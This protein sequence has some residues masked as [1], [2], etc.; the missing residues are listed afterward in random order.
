VIERRVGREEVERESVSMKK[1]PAAK[2]AKIGGG[3]R[4]RKSGDSLMAA[5][6]AVKNRNGGGRRLSK[7]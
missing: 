5:S 2:M 3:R 7:A 4:R 1:R 6:A